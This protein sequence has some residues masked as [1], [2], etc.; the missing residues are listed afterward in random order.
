MFSIIVNEGAPSQRQ[1][2][3]GARSAELLGQ[4]KTGVRTE[5]ITGINTGPEKSRTSDVLHHSTVS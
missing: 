4:P 2:G 1:R 5:G 3:F